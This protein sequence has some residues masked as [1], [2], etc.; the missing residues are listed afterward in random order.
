MLRT[1]GNALKPDV[2]IAVDGDSWK[3]RSEST[4]KNTEINFK[5]GEE[6]DEKTADGRECKVR[7][8]EK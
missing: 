5:L 2:V 3:L 7:N 6:F 4:F 8:D 1:T